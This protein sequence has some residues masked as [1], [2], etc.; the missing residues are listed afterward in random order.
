[1]IGFAL[2]KL[3]WISLLACLIFLP[4]EAF[5]GTLSYTYD[6]LNR[7]TQVQYGNGTTINYTYGA[8]RNRTGQVVRSIVPALVMINIAKVTDAARQLNGLHG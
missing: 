7:V 1:M 3:C 2:H 6:A 4:L 8:A 5:A